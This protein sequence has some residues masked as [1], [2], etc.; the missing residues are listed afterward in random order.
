MA[1]P[2]PQRPE[3]VLFDAGGTLIQP[4]VHRLL[5]RMATMTAGA[6]AGTVG[7]DGPGV[8]GPG[9]DGPRADGARPDLP[10]AA[11][12]DAALWRAMALFN[13]TFGPSA[14]DPAAWIPEWLATWAR[15]VGVDPQLL[16]AAWHAE[17]EIAHIWDQPI[18]GAARCL[19]RLRDAGIAVGVVSNSDG[20]VDAALDRAGLALHLQVVVDSGV[21]GVAKPDPRIF[22]T[23]LAALAADPGAT[24]YVGDT[25]VYDVA[26]ADAAGLVA[27]VVDHRGL[28]T[29]GHPRTARSLDALT[30]RA[31]QAP[32]GRRA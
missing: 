17:D 29:H 4:N 14:G 27:W 32:P 15:D 24:W 9:V 26:A 7:V 25:V 2:A 10:T 11:D 31:V 20:R 18:D 21:V 13:T 6:G 23:A 16:S 19:R 1:G 5:R 3:A 28:H 8:D 30:D 12:L 22:D